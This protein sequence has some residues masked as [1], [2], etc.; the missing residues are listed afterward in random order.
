MNKTTY[1]KHLTFSIMFLI[2]STIF[3]QD[4]TCGMVEHMNKK[5][6][7]PEFAKKYKESQSKFRQALEYNLRNKETVFNSVDPIIIPVAIHFPEG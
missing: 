3:A 7:N 4:R 5:M 2:C 1:K 6:L